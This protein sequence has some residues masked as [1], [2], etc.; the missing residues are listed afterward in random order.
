MKVRSKIELKYSA[1]RDGIKQSI[2]EIE[3]RMTNRDDVR[4]VYSFSEIDY[5]VDATAVPNPMQPG[6]S[7][8]LNSKY[9]EKTYAEY[10]QDLLDMTAADTSGLTGSALEDKLLQDKLFKEVTEGKYYT[11]VASNWERV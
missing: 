9:F 1:G 8:V 10:D 11:S 4:K 2:I 7:N 5:S 6:G 3:L